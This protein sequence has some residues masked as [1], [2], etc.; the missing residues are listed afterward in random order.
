MTE[1]E[2]RMSSDSNEGLAV[3]KVSYRW[4]DDSKPSCIEPENYDGNLGAGFYAYVYVFLSWAEQ[5]KRTQRVKPLPGKQWPGSSIYESKRKA[6]NWRDEL[7]AEPENDRH[8]HIHPIKATKSKIRLK[9]DVLSASRI[10]V[11]CDGRPASRDQLAEMMRRLRAQH[12]PPD[13]QP[14]MPAV[15]G[16]ALV[17]YKGRPVIKVTIVDPIDT[18]TPAQMRALIRWINEFAP[19]TGYRIMSMS[20]GSTN[21]YIQVRTNNQSVVVEGLRTAAG[22]SAGSDEG[23]ET[24][25][26]ESAGQ[27]EEPAVSLVVG[28]GEEPNDEDINLFLAYHYQP[29]ERRNLTA[30]FRESLPLLW[31]VLRMPREGFNTAHSLFHFA[32]TLLVGWR[33]GRGEGP[34]DALYHRATRRGLLNAFLLWPVFTLAIG[35]VIS[36]ALLPHAPAATLLFVAGNSM[37]LGFAASLVCGPLFNIL[38]VGAGGVCFG[39]AFAIV[40]SLLIRW[41]QSLDIVAGLA[42]NADPFITVVAGVIGTSAPSI[43]G[44]GQKLLLLLVPSVAI[45]ATAWLMGNPRSDEPTQAPSDLRIIAG[46]LAGLVGGIGIGAIMGLLRLL[47]VIGM[48]DALAFAIAAGVVGA[49]CFGLCTWLR[50]NGMPAMQRLRRAVMLGTCYGALGSPLWLCAL[51]MRGTPAG[52]F[53]IAPST[54]YLHAC[55]FT[56]SYSIGF[57][58]AGKRAACLAAAAEG[59]GGFVVANSIF[60]SPANILWVLVAALATACIGFAVWF[61]VAIRQRAMHP[62]VSDE[63]EELQELDIVDEDRRRAAA[64]RAVRNLSNV[65]PPLVFIASLGVIL[66]F[67]RPAPDLLPI[68][69]RAVHYTGIVLLFV[70]LV[71]GTFCQFETWSKLRRSAPLNS[72]AQTYRRWWVATKLMPAPAAICILVGGLGLVAATPSRGILEFGWLFWLIVGFSFFF[73]DGLTFYLPEICVRYATVQ[74]AFQA[75]MPVDLYN[76]RF[77]TRRS[78]SMLLIHAI[79]FPFVFALGAA[80]PD[81]LWVPQSSINWLYQHLEILR[82]ERALVGAPIVL[83]FAVAAIVL[84][85]RIHGL[86]N[87]LK[88]LKR[89]S[90]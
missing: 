39:I 83:I 19:D 86:I 7:L 15:A 45:A 29:F 8:Q 70:F 80:K 40:N 28:P 26:I 34:L 24:E 69:T 38:G 36:A 37:L 23:R 63:G 31:H 82:F 66:M 49:I 56:L 1:L 90:W 30:R 85:C 87:H 84:L 14:Q 58:I 35:W 20:R 13:D 89:Y 72:I 76:M 44:A 17:T 60:L 4:P 53:L 55:Y 18:V 33:T 64:D 57:R 2:I 68:A 48:N 50:L 74:H 78:E 52:L 81:G 46:A 67:H 54:G 3:T 47:E 25:W 61:A 65:L 43:T 9:E 79:S 51:A 75:R 62:V 73:V 11:I 16:V 59:I 71:F 42:R 77:R 6:V 10:H 41:T 22:E 21:L 12:G 27:F 32:T 88:L 5:W